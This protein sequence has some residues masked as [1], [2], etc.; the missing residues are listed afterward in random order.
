MIL[1]VSA[2]ILCQSSHRAA[3]EGSGSTA[4]SRRDEV[5]ASAAGLSFHFPA[6]VKWGG[7]YLST[8]LGQGDNL[9]IECFDIRD[10]RFFIKPK[11][12]FPP[13]EK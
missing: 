7:Y 12:V 10:G 2:R 4:Q 3:E 8:L 1:G 11:Y 9:A 6:P 5:S 13:K